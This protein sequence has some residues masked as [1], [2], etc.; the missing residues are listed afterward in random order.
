[1]RSLLLFSFPSSFSFSF[2]FFHYLLALLFSKYAPA[3]DYASASHETRIANANSKATFTCPDHLNLDLRWVFDNGDALECATPPKIE[4]DY[5]DLSE[6]G[7]KGCVG[8]LLSTL[9]QFF[10]WEI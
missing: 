3:F 5:L 1:M 8:V 9:S 6:R 4:L 2:P 7:H 10:L